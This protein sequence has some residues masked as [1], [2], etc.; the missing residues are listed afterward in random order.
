MLGG[1][2]GEKSK[3]V[4]L[5][6]DKIYPTPSPI[7]LCNI[8][9]SSQVLRGQ[10]S[11]VNFLWSPLCTVSDD[12]APPV[13]P[14]HHV[15]PSKIFR[16]P[17]PHFPGD[18]REGLIPYPRIIQSKAKL[19]SMKSN[20]WERGGWGMGCTCVSIF[21]TVMKMRPHSASHPH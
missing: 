19:R 9:L 16:L 4:W 6:Y 5:C 11:I 10:F 17:P 1:G 14:E 12:C 20:T 8:L 15:I 3:G 13:I 18:N 2:G 21:F 7:R